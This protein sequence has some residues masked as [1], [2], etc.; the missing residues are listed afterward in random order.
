MATR[1]CLAEARPPQILS[2]KIIQF[3][4]TMSMKFS[5]IN[6]WVKGITHFYMKREGGLDKTILSHSHLKFLALSS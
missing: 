2:L 5:R 6:I 1:L 4:I 3:L